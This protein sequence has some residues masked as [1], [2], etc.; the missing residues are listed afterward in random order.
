MIEPN[1]ATMLCYILTDASVEE[2]DWN[3]IL[4]PA[5][6]V[7]FNAISIDGDEST[8]DT[9]VLIS[10]DKIKSDVTEFREA[11]TT[12]CQSLAAD[13]VRN[14][15]G[16]S[17]V[18]RI[19]LTNYAVERK[20]AIKLGR[21]IVNSPLFKCAVAGNDPNIGRLAAAVGSFLGKME[22]EESVDASKISF[23]IGDDLIFSNGVFQIDA[24][25]IGRAHVELQ[26][27][28]DLVCRL[29]L[30][31]KKNNNKTTKKTKKKNKQ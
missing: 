14:G 21:K 19:T 7:S 4:T 18:I 12:L 5:V 2:E 6:D 3:G 22:G 20:T 27:H 16:T 29:L 8:S 9:V 28:H 1:M 26:S 10:S 24:D 30:E 15:E 11:L 25:E 17:H 13:L 23:S 31:K